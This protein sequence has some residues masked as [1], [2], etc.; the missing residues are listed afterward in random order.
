MTLTK[1]NIDR[2]IATVTF[3]NP[4]R[5]YM[6][7]AQMQEIDRLADELA[8]DDAVRVVVFTGGVENVFIRHYDVAEILGFA[9]ALQKTK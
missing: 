7:A 1:L 9:D 5:G 2:G 4:P 3:A 8:A 6:N